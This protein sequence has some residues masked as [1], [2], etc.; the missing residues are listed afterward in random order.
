MTH[1]V[2]LS[3]DNGPEPA[4]TP[5]VLDTLSA[6]GVLASFF[7]L[8][9]NMINPERRKLAERAAAEGHWIGNHTFTHT[10]PFG[11]RSEPD[12][13]ETEIGRTQALIGDLSH[14]D[15]FFRPIGGGGKL[16]RHL[17]GPGTVEFLKGGRYSCVLWNSVPRDW[18]DAEGWVD[19]ALDQISRQPWS[20]VVLHDLPTGAM[21]H[22]ARF[23]DRVR[24]GGGRLRQDFPPECVPI[25]RGDVTL[26]LGEW[27]SDSSPTA[28]N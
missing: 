16:G 8:G 17:L 3:F 6:S 25:R 13:A 28:P 7:V 19:R 26:A 2:T 10:V 5:G 24:E 18:E 27:V 12:A 20:L 23:I 14:P 4:V 1:D 15:R 9:K 21:R 11:R 22:L